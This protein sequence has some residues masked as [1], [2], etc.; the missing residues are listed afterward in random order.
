MCQQSLKFPLSAAQALRV[1]RFVLSESEKAEL[2]DYTYVYY[3]KASSNSLQPRD[4][5]AY[6]YEVRDLLGRGH[7]ASVFLC[8]DHKR[9]EQVALKV[10]D[11][12]KRFKAQAAVEVNALAAL[13]NRSV[14]V[15][16]LKNYFVFRQQVCIVME[17]LG[18][19]LG[20]L[21]RL[22]LEQTK[23]V[24]V[25]LLAAL[26]CLSRCEVIHCDLKPAN[27][28][29]RGQEVSLIDFGSAC[30]AN[31]KSSLYVQARFYRAPE[32]LLGIAYTTAIDMWSFGCIVY[33]LFT[34]RPLFPAQSEQD[35]LDKIVQLKGPPPERVRA[36]ATRV[37]A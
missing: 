26:D 16:S 9:K 36:Q 20:S 35:L 29:L 4:H 21:G 14:H 5:V 34:G 31:A 7:S 10:I 15:V 8:F 17:C 37:R 3:Y 25:Q 6:R 28:L 24:G 27:V 30:F 12:K 22:G 1:L 19:R 23:A 18:P 11:A 13:R 32:V 2:A 33:E